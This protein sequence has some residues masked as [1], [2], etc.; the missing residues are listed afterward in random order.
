MGLLVVSA[1]GIFD[2]VLEQ[3]KQ[4]VGTPFLIKV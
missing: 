1:H 3:Y 4:I 2:L